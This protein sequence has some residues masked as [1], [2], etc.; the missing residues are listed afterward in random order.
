MALVDGWHRKMSATSEDTVRDGC[1][2]GAVPAFE[3]HDQ[4]HHDGVASSFPIGF[5][6]LFGNVFAFG[7]EL[8]MGPA[9]GTLEPLEW[10]TALVTFP[11]RPHQREFFL[12]TAYI[13][14]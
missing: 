5:R 8:R 10:A 2:Y 11:V 4:S 6:A 7:I 1:R 14:A 12:A 13:A 9:I 3:I